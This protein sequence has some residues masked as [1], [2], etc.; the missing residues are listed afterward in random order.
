MKKITKRIFA[1]IF[2]LMMV[3]QQ[4][5]PLL[6]TIVKADPVANSREVSL[7]YVD[8]TS[9]NTDNNV[10]TFNNKS[11]SKSKSKGKKDFLPKPFSEKNKSKIKKCIEI[12]NNI[13]IY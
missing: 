3:S 12:N 7:E 8:A 10:V 1:W 11:K 5:S 4:F 6:L 13:N 9:V 2:C